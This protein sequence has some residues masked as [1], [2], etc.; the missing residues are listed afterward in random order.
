M[1]QVFIVKEN[2]P[3]LVLFFAG[4]GMDEHVFYD[5]RPNRSDLMICYDYRSLSFDATLLAP[6][7]S[8]YVV[9]WSMGVWAAEQIFIN[10]GLK[11]MHM[12]AYNG[13]PFPVSDDFGIASTVYQGTYDG[14]NEKTLSKFYKRMCGS[15]SSMLE[16]EQRLPKRSIEELKQELLTIKELSESNNIIGRCVWDKAIIGNNDRIFLSDNQRKAWNGYAEVLYVDS[17][18]YDCSLLKKLVEEECYG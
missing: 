13:T 11:K 17:A 6:Y 14:L 8:V 12:V 9:A 4:W 18:H 7:S 3:K 15:I 16:F 2:N 1:K 5:H 10:G